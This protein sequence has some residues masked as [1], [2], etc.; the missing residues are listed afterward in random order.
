MFNIL[1]L[2]LAGCLPFNV[3]VDEGG[4][5]FKT[6]LHIRSR[7]AVRYSFTI[8]KGKIDC[9]IIIQAGCQA[10]KPIILEFILDIDNAL[11]VCA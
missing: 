4:H 6:I 10:G 5:S 9:L 2:F 7:P 11:L 3:F 1:M 8:L